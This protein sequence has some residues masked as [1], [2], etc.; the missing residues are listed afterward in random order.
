M[1]PGGTFRRILVPTDGSSHATDAA[2]VALDVAALS[3]AEVVAVYV[4]SV[5]ALAGAESA[6]LP[7]F[8]ER[9]VQEGHAHLDAIVELGRQRGITVR[10][11]VMEEYGW[12]PDAI[13]RAARDEACDL[14]VMGSRGLTGLRKLFLGSVAYAVISR[15]PC[16]VLVVRKPGQGARS[17]GQASS[18]ET[19]RPAF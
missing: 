5:R 2:H 17:S 11:R 1:A 19:G 4:L 3:G 6:P 15:A 7:P 9:R 8:L 16:P 18:T 12:T 10:P 13:I 14:I